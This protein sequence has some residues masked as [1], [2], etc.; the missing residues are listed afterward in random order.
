MSQFRTVPDTVHPVPQ[1]QKKAVRG[2]TLIEL[3]VV[4][5]IIAI[6]I[7]LLLPAVQQAREAARRL[8]CKNNLKQLGIAVHNYLDQHDYIVPVRI[9]NHH[10]WMALLLPHIDQ[11]NVHDTYDFDRPWDHAVNQPAVTAILPVLHCASSPANADYLYDIGNN[12]RASTTDYGPSHAIAR[13]RFHNPPGDATG[14]IHQNTSSIASITDGTISTLLF[15]EDA[16]R[17]D[18]YV[19]GKPGPSNSNNGCGNFNVSGG[20]VKGGAWSS[21]RNA[22][23]L[24][25]FTED[26]LRCPG[27]CAIN[28][29]NNNEAYSFHTGGIQAV[30]VDGHVQFLS[31]NIHLSI[32]HA[33][34]TARGNEVVGE[35]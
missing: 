32:Y 8:S 12:R 5:A 7:A 14:A 34:I 30:F 4:I 19:A 25:G 29:T 21:P 31:E 15:I 28:C 17:P 35:F 2:F 1:T 24:H 16:G 20:I 10:S 3:L 13:S 27:P 22:L 11:G 9:R 23:P 33:L 6:L 18:H 26:G